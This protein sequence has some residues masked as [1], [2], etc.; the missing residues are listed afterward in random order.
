MEFRNLKYT[1]KLVD[2]EKPKTTP[3]E[4]IRYP[5]NWDEVMQVFETTQRETG[6]TLTWVEAERA[7]EKAGVSNKTQAL[8]ILKA[9][10][11]IESK[12]PQRGVDDHGVARKGSRMTRGR[13]CADGCLPVLPASASPKT[14]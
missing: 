13:A 7:F 2:T 9:K 8:L 5:D 11:L 12:V 6:R 4:A 14:S 3:D 10:G 1:R